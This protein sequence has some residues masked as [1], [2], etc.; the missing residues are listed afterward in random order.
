MKKLLVYLLI[1]FMGMPLLAQN[2]KRFLL[3]GQMFGRH[4]LAN[5]N[6]TFIWGF[7][8]QKT[9]GNIPPVQL[10]APTIVVNEGDSVEVMFINDSDEG[11]TIHFHGLDTDQEN[12]GVPHT[13]NFVLTGDTFTYKFKATHA[14]N[15]I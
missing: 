8:H 6:E 4:T 12:D 5:G 9:E 14:G 1:F 15:Y 13:S 3:Y 11:H 7:S 2:K 10:P